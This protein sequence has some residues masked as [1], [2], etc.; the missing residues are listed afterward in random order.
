MRDFYMTL[1]SNSSMDYHP[2]NKT[3]SFTVQVPRYIR[4]EGEWEVGLAEIQYPYTFHTVS[5][6]HNQ[7]HLKVIAVTEEFMKWVTD[8]PKLMVSEGN[9]EEENVTCSIVSGYY[10]EIQDIVSTVNDSIKK[11][12]GTAKVLEYE[13]KTRTIKAK[14]SDVQIN[15][16]YIVSC[17]LSDRLSIQL[18][19]P[20]G[21]NIFSVKK[22][23]F[24]SNV[25]F[26]VPDRMIIYCDIIE[27]QIFGDSFAR[28]LNSVNTLPEGE[29]NFGKTFSTYLTVPQ[30]IPVQAQVF[31]SVS[32]DIRD[33]EGKS[34]PFQY[35]TLSVKLHFR[36]R[37][38]N[39]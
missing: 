29:A 23:P 12:T 11:A 27:P 21:V 18:G 14:N 28:V 20:T 24:G 6:E 2:K 4:L 19:Y 36:Q 31:E 13:A 1:L 7:I 5:G 9:F 22:A 32:I 16:K 17:T 10:S 26:G 37:S 30:Y 3:S 25:K 35:G 39:F 38:A 15:G 8:N 33:V 34:M